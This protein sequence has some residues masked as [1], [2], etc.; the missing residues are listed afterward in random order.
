MAKKELHIMMGDKNDPIPIPDCPVCNKPMQRSPLLDRGDKEAFICAKDLKKCM[1]QV[2]RLDLEIEGGKVKAKKLT[3]VKTP[4][5]TPKSDVVNTVIKIQRPMA[6]NFDVPEALIYTKGRKFETTIPMTEELY[7]LFGEDVKQY[8][9]ANISERTYSI[10]MV[11]Q[12]E[13]QPW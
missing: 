3:K 12:V 8:W 6:G 10:E 2:V 13:D 7:E 1:R 5:K 11:R 9:E 4:T